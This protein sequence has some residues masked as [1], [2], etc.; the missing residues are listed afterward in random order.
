[1]LELLAETDHLVRTMYARAGGRRF[2]RG[3]FAI[4]SVIHGHKVLVIAALKRIIAD[5]ES[6]PELSFS[7][8]GLFVTLLKLLPCR[9]QDACQATCQKILL[10][11]VKSSGYGAKASTPPASSS[12]WVLPILSDVFGDVNL[13]QSHYQFSVKVCY[14]VIYIFSELKLS[15]AEGEVLLAPKD[16]VPRSPLHSPA[17]WGAVTTPYLWNVAIQWKFLTKHNKRK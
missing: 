17:A 10:H 1:M 7:A 11:L 3:V 2:C 6:A 5:S 8:R 16:G 14:P 15:G 9:T 13:H 12:S 4:C